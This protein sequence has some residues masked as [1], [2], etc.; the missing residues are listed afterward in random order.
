MWSPSATSKC[1]TGLGFKTPLALG[2]SGT[3]I[4][5][6][7]I[8]KE[9]TVEP[10]LTHTQTKVKGWGKWKYFY[11]KMLID[12]YLDVFVCVRRMSPYTIVS[13]LITFVLLQNSSGF[14]IMKRS[15]PF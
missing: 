14:P 12:K 5:V 1:F 15:R 9:A 3:V 4:L 8:S 6:Q 2:Q 7:K 10:S 13:Q 11:V